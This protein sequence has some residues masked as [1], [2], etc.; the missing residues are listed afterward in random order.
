MLALFTGCSTSQ[1]WMRQVHFVRNEYLV[2][3]PEHCS[4]VVVTAPRGW[5]LDPDGT[6]ANLG[7]FTHRVHPLSPI[8]ISTE[9]APRIK[10]IT[11]QS[12][13]YAH[14]FREAQ[15]SEKQRL[16]DWR[17][18]RAGLNPALRPP[19]LSHDPENY[20]HLSTARLPDGREVWVS[21]FHSPT[22]GYSLRAFIPED[23]FI[24]SFLQPLEGSSPPPDLLTAM[25]MT[26]KS[27]RPTQHR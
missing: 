18:L 1:G 8:V 2:P 22:S 17:R 23:G 4:G 27:Y 3:A 9:N 11:S 26:V 25:T 10:P 19:P 16:A 21:C 12:A 24:T 6:P 5:R 14:E 13:V 20:R 15:R 7:S